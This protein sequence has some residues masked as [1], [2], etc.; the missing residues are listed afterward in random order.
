MCQSKIASQIIQQHKAGELI[1]SRDYLHTHR[2]DDIVII[3]I[4]ASKTRNT[5]MKQA[6]FKAIADNLAHSPGVRS[7][8]VLIVLSYNDREDW[9]FGKG[10]APH[11]LMLRCRAARSK[12]NL[13]GDQCSRQLRKLTLDLLKCKITIGV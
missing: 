13:L 1:Y 2:T 9:S 10:L 7:E 11:T 8:D 12:H 5:D 4:V 3:Q 6:L